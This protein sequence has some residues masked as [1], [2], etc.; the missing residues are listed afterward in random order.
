MWNELMS[1]Y[2][3]WVDQLEN[4][5]AGTEVNANNFSEID[6]QRLDELSFLYKHVF[7]NRNEIVQNDTQ[8]NQQKDCGMNEN[9][10][11][12]SHVLVNNSHTQNQKVNSTYSSA[13]YKAGRFKTDPRFQE[14]LRNKSAVEK[15]LV[16]YLEKGTIE[17]ELKKIYTDAL[18][19]MFSKMNDN[20]HAEWYLKVVSSFDNPDS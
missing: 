11:A 2:V 7:H 20:E 17:E 18:C 12:K 3:R 8:R 19:D 16:T 5:P 13:D 9:A 10:S 1:N 15:G 14:I 6:F 4:A